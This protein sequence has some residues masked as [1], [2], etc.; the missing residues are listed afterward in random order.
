MQIHVTY[1][2]ASP[3]MQQ[4][5]AHRAGQ[6]ASAPN[7]SVRTDHLGVESLACAPFSSTA[8]ENKLKAAQEVSENLEVCASK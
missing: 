8:D 1:W 6:P 2:L 5:V 7:H 4:A 3:A